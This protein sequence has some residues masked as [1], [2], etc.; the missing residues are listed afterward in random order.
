MGKID[1]LKNPDG[2]PGITKNYV[3]GCKGKCIYC[4]A[5][6]YGKRFCVEMA[7]TDMKFKYGREWF[8]EPHYIWEYIQLKKD[9]QQFIPTFRPSVL[10]QNLPRK[11]TMIFFSMSDPAYWK[12]EWYKKILKKICNNFQHTFVIL[13]KQPSI[14]EK[15]TFPHNCWLGVTIENQPMINKFE[16][17]LNNYLE[18]FNKLFSAAP[19]TTSTQKKEKP[20]TQEPAKT[21]TTKAPVKEESTKDKKKKIRFKK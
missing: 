19:P 3:F 9:F 13:T 10:A 14:Y 15:Y 2:S 20:K 7:M 4:Y 1:W 5:R 21:E 16:Y 8:L 11:P 17:E 12:Q 18:I 6:P